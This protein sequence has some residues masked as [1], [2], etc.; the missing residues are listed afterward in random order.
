MKSLYLLLYDKSIL[1]TTIPLLDWFSKSVRT[2]PTVVGKMVRWNIHC[3]E[4]DK[5]KL[6]E[7]DNW[8]SMESKNY[9]ESICFD[10]EKKHISELSNQFDS[11]EQYEI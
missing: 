8:G 3:Y 4:C 9:R 7:I 1:N 6:S 2:C 10:C 11:I 5:I